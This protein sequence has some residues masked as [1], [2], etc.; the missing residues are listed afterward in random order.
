VERLKNVEAV[1][2]EEIRRLERQ[3]EGMRR[4]VREESE[5]YERVKGLLETAEMEKRG[6]DERV[7]T[8]TKRLKESQKATVKATKEKEAAEREMRGAAGEAQQKGDALL[9]ER[10]TQLANMEIAKVQLEGRIAGLEREKEDLREEL[11]VAARQLEQARAVQEQG[12]SVSEQQWSSKVRELEE[13]HKKQL[14]D[15]RATNAQLMDQASGFVEQEKKMLELRVQTLEGTLRDLNEEKEAKQAESNEAIRDLEAALDELERDS[16]VQVARAVREGEQK[17]Q[18][19]ETKFMRAESELL[20]EVEVAKSKTEALQEQLT[21][22]RDVY[23]EDKK[24]AATRQETEVRALE[25]E[26]KSV[27]EQLESERQQKQDLRSKDKDGLTGAASDVVAGLSS[28][29]SQKTAE[30]EAFKESSEETVSTL[31]RLVEATDVENEQLRRCWKIFVL[32]CLR[33]QCRYCGRDVLTVQADEHVSRCMEQRGIMGWH[34]LSIPPP[35]LDVRV[36]VGGSMMQNVD[37]KS[38]RVYLLEVRQGC[39]QWEVARRYSDFIRLHKSLKGR[40]QR[41]KLPD[42][43]QLQANTASVFQNE[44]QTIDHRRAQIGDYF[45]QVL[46]ISAVIECEELVAFLELSD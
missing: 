34:E 6:A 38:K 35:G 11:Q 22:L 37:G 16:T 39:E 3:M 12:M 15:I 32:H 27:R 41:V 36:E 26:V 1:G 30:L 14:A 25:R 20:R 2:I 8:L 19:A 10:E 24:E 7:A 31:N 42:I 28:V 21:E 13:S 45:A 17:L 4:E 46:K 44:A 23:K 33:V 18:A 5:R 9:I 43:S 40:L 29:L